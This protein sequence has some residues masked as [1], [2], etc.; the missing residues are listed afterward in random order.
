MESLECET[1]NVLAA[2]PMELPRFNFTAPPPLCFVNIQENLRED[3]FVVLV[4]TI[5]R[6]GWLCIGLEC[7]KQTPMPHRHT[8]ESEEQYIHCRLCNNCYGTHAH[9]LAGLVN[10]E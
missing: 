4:L 10:N 7:G 5:L 2:S 8:E 9:S 1:A 3:L 6:R